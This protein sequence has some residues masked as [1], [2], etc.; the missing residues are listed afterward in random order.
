MLKT[1]NRRA[2]VFPRGG[3]RCTWERDAEFPNCTSFNC[4]TSHQATYAK[5][6]I[7]FPKL[8]GICDVAYN[9]IF[10]PNRARGVRTAHQSN[11]WWARAPEPKVYK[12]IQILRK[13]ESQIQ[14]KVNRVREYL[15]TRDYARNKLQC[16]AGASLVA[17]DL[18]SIRTTFGSDLF[19]RS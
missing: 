12:Y 5:M 14:F 13:N 15:I 7:C 1:R 18:V 8:R 16:R 3:K 9:F 2:R 10:F 17:F 19:Y 11:S 4:L 6:Q